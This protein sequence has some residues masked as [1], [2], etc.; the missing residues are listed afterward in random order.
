MFPAHLPFKDLKFGLPQRQRRPGAQDCATNNWIGKS[1]KTLVEKGLL[2]IYIHTAVYIYIYTLY[3]CVYIYTLYVY[4]Y[5]YIYTV[6][7]YIYTLYIYIYMHLYIYIH[8]YC[9]YIYIYIPVCVYMYPFIDDFTLKSGRFPIAAR[10]FMPGQSGSHSLFFQAINVE[11]STM[12]RP[13]RTS[14][15]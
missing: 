2:Y 9:T 12:L 11:I 8:I 7:I 1:A 13:A 10:C 5:I 3:V 14:A 6:Y 15:V 4:I